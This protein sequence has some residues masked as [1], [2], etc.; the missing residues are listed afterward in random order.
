M[1]FETMEEK[2]KTIS[3][4]MANIAWNENDW[5]SPSDNKTN[6]RWTQVEGNIPHESWNFDF[7]NTRNSEE[8]FLDLFNLHIHQRT[9]REINF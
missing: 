7:D 8:K 9:P 6:F 4:I 5:K 2:N 1:V 3:C